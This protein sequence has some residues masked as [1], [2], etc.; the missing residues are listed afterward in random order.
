[1]RKTFAIMA[2]GAAIL[3]TPA[4]AQLGG[5]ADVNVGGQVGVDPGNSVGNTLGTV[6]D[7]VGDTVEKVDGT[8]NH[9]ADHSNLTLA[10]REQVRAGAEVRDS[11]G[12]SVGTVQSVE[13]NTA[14]VVRGGKLYNI[15]LA[16]L[17]NSAS[18]KAKGLVTKL[19]HAE[20]TAR[21]NA[22]ADVRR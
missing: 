5:V 10:T 13:G 7:R 6:T 4:L 8:V 18:G 14:V 9:A 2:A 22:G 15:P 21:A 20:I 19:P 16:S 17:Y 12:T 1:M 11:S 3:A